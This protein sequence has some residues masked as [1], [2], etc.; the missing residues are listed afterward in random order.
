MFLYP[1]L[2][3]QLDTPRNLDK[4]LI[5]EIDQKIHIWRGKCFQEDGISK[6]EYLK[7]IIVNY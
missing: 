3:I 7:K 5:V 1:F 4:Q 2:S 6:E